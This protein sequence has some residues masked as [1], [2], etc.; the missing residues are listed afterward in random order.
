MVNRRSFVGMAAIAGAALLAGCGGSNASGSS[1]A[2]S[3]AA[4]SSASAAS[5]SGSSAALSVGT[6]A[7]EDLL[8]LWVAQEE[9]LFEKAGLAADIVTFQSA[10]ELISGVTSGDVNMA[11]TDIMVAASICAGGTDVRMQWVTLGTNP[12]QGRFG[13]M[14]GPGSSVKTL[15]DL[16]G[17]P[18]GVGSNTILEYVMD[19]LMEGAGVSDDQI[20]VEELQKLPVRYQAMESGQ[21]AAAA[22]PASL[23]ALGEASGCTTIADDTKDENIS[24]SVMIARADALGD[25]ARADAVEKLKKVWDE[26]AE[27]VNDN[28]ERYRS[29]LISHANLS[30]VVAGTYPICE[31]PS[32]M[33][34]TNSMVDP[35]LEWMQGKG[36]LQKPLTYDEK[37]GSFSA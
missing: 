1:A 37:T 32:C 28:P 17:V 12:D 15:G 34:P 2:G 14:V 3:S 30:D 22:L 19:K 33:M 8:P 11:M 6:L 36:Y 18:I 4:G 35:V 5:T 23:L 29:V 9:G 13:I 24:Q 16:A 27:L 31:Y 20:V 7:T 10:S 21:V 25:A 26:A